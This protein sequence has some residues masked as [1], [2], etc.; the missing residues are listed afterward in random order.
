M[1]G[2]VLDG[3]VREADGGLPPVLLQRRQRVPG[4]VRRQRR[5]PDRLLLRRRR[6]ELRSDEGERQRLR[7]RQRVHENQLRRQ[8]LLWDCELPLM[9]GLQRPGQRGHLLGDD[10][11]QRRPERHLRRSGLHEL[12]HERQ[13]RRR[14]R[15]PELPRRHDLLAGHLQGHGDAQPGGRVQRRHLQGRHEAVRAVHVRGGRVRQHVQQRHG[16]RQRHLLQRRQV[17]RQPAERRRVRPGGA[18]AL[19]LRQLRRR[20]LLR[21]GLHGRL[22]VVRRCAAPSAP[23]RPQA[24]ARRSARGLQGPWHEAAC[25]T[26]GLCDGDGQLPE[27][28]VAGTVCSTELVPRSGPRQH[29]KPGRAR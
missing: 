19:R 27:L 2:D 9:Q 10:R 26:N 25:A 6:R 18:P 22:P 17:R 11:G 23:A 4:H 5:L 7:Q 21:H 14:R 3:L 1:A 13:V 16:L 29:T 20:R 12:R 15:L 24:Q 28:L 8:V